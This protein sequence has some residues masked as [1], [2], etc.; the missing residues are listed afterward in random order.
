MKARTRLLL[1]A[2]L[3]ATPL[4]PAQDPPE[5]P[6]AEAIP[7]EGFWPTKTMLH[8]ML[9]RIAD[10]MG[11][12]YEMD[13][14]QLAQL[15]ALLRERVPEW[16]NQNRPQIMN[17]MNQF[18]EAQLADEPP[19][20]AM[21]TEW[22]GKMLGLTDSFKGMVTGVTDNMREFMTDD[23]QVRLDAEMAAFQTGLTLVNNKLNVWAEG[24]YD[25]AVDWTPPGAARRERERAEERAAAAE[26]EKARSEA[27]AR[28]G[29]P[30]AGTEVTPVGAE[31]AAVEANKKDAAAAKP[32]PVDEWTKYTDEFIARY[33]LNDEQSQKARL[34]LKEMQQKRDEYLRSKGADMERVTKQLKDAKS[35]DERKVAQLASD[36]LSEPVNR[37]FT[38]LKDRLSRIPTREQRR[39]AAKHDA[40]TTPAAPAEQPEKPAKP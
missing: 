10:E 9:G 5:E 14:D 3:L 20:V 16:M 23:Q 8:N 22:S 7:T 39:N 1:V 19:D 12:Q 34:H 4:A 36:K 38:Q 27:Y 33:K 21:V 2:T 32:K 24:G 35:D 29:N 25:P 11:D 17:L 13:D 30:P 31:P 37:L 6:A 40:E 26:M 28:S 18:F 15:T